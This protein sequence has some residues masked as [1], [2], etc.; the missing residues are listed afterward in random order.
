MKICPFCFHEAEQVDHNQCRC[1]WCGTFLAKEDLT[2]IRIIRFFCPKC[3][4]EMWTG[5]SEG[6]PWDSR[7]RMSL[8]ELKRQLECSDC[9]LLEIHRERLDR[10]VAQKILNEDGFVDNQLL[11]C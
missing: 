2:E 1:T 8:F 3:G 10:K 11:G 5:L 4:K 7:P 6:E 9:L